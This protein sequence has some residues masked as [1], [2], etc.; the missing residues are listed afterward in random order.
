MILDLP[1]EDVGFLIEVLK[2]VRGSPIVPSEAR[3]QAKIVQ[4]K[5]QSQ[6]E[7][8]EVVP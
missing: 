8:K 2:R 4:D 3:Q 6:T 7:T 1:S 5:I